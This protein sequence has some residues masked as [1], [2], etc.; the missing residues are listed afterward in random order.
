MCGGRNDIPYQAKAGRVAVVIAGVSLALAACTGS[1]IH[2]R[3]SLGDVQTLSLDAKQRLVVSG[4]DPEGDRIL[5]A[6]PSPDA[7]VAR[8][9]CYPRVGHIMPVQM[10]QRVQVARAVVFRS[11]PHQAGIAPKACKY[12]AMASIG[13]VKPI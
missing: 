11:L 13:F 12:F 7:L 6:E 8:P 4:K 2:K 1:T 10:G 3:S 9:L 5:C